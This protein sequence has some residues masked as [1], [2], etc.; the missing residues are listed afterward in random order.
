[1]PVLTSGGQSDSYQRGQ[2]QNDL[3]SQA[4]DERPPPTPFMSKFNPQS[5]IQLLIAG[6]STSSH[7]TNASSVLVG[8][9][10]LSSQGVWFHCCGE[11]IL[12]LVNQICKLFTYDE[13]SI[14]SG[15]SKFDE[16]STC[17]PSILVV[18]GIGSLLAA[19]WK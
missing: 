13:K 6:C 19:A 11:T 4:L 8:S 1:M 17:R 15:S 9:T 14:F 10:R 7:L 5:W 16:N 2:R 12:Q 3:N 18:A